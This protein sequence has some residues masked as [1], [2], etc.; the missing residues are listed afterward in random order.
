MKYLNNLHEVLD[1]YQQTMRH[2]D[3]IVDNT[4]AYWDQDALFTATVK[5]ICE[6]LP[7]TVPPET[8][9]LSWKEIKSTINKN[10]VQIGDGSIIPYWDEIKQELGFEEED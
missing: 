9:K 1:Y 10:S 7:F 3:M 8:R 5:V 2:G 6:S 4:G